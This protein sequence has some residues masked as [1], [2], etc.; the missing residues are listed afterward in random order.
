M[1]K[2]GEKIIN[3]IYLGDKKI[4]KV[5][6]GNKLVFQAGKPI[7]IEYIESTGTQY[8]DTGINGTEVTRFVIKGTCLPSG[9]NNS[10]F[11]GGTQSSSYTFFGAR[12]RTA[13]MKTNWYCTNS[14]DISIGDPS[15]LSIIE[16]TIESKTSQYGTLTDLV[17]GSVKE[18]VKFSTSQWGFPNENLLLFGGDSQ[19]RSPNATCYM[20]QLYTK[21]GLVRDLRPC[22]DAKGTVCMY[23]MVTKK[24]YYNQGTGTLTAGN[25]INFVDYIIFDGKSYIDT[26]YKPNPN[27]SVSVTYNPHYNSVFSCIFGTQ[28]GAD[29]NRFYALISSTPYRV[30]VNSCKSSTAYFGISENG[31]VTNS[32]GTFTS[33]QQKVEL[34]IDNYNKQISV[35]SDELTKT[36]NT[37]QYSSTHHTPECRYSMLLGDRSSGGVPSTSNRFKGEIYGFE[38]MESGELVQDL[39]PCVV[40]GEACFYDMVTGK[41]FTNTG[42]GTLGYTE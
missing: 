40:A 24:Y 18:F 9:Q 17:D 10:Q 28:D 34:T 5:F 29:T 26:G 20:L 7:F 4:A 42:T 21:D 33:Q 39:R 11:L 15:H 30:Q 27:S 2:L 35:K 41:I 38:I 37:E 25:K 32:N 16:A 6:L 8:I 13:E 22:I 23:D 12:Y 14:A 31:L 3:Q 19:R 1:L 36:Y